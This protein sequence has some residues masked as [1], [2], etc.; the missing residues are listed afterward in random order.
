MYKRQELHSAL[1]LT[2]AAVVIG[3]CFNEIMHGSQTALTLSRWQSAGKFAI[4]LELMIDARSVFDSVCAEII[5]TPADR[6]LLIHAKALREYLE[7][8]QLKGLRWIDTRDMVSDALNK[9]SVD[10]IAIVKFFTSGVWDTKFESKYFE[11]RT[12]T[13]RTKSA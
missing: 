12:K 10:R 2:G 7:S 6:A 3:S 13:N 11:P 1:D 5:K 8:K 4:P 9:G